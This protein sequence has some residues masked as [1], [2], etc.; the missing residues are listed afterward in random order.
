M[1]I[2]QRQLA[3]NADQDGETIRAILAALAAA[4]AEDD[5]LVLQVVLGTAAVPILVPRDALDDSDLVVISNLCRNAAEAAMSRVRVLVTVCDRRVH[6][7]VDDDGPGVVATDVGRIFERGVSSKGSGAE[8]GVGL[9]LVRREIG[10]RGGTVEVG[11]S[12]W[13]G[14]RFTV[15]APAVTREPVP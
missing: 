12:P 13:G 14:A 9:D 4:R 1:R 7:E 3:L 6:I 2:R 10:V 5:V 15:D 8:R 11:R